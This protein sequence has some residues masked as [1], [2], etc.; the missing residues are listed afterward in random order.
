MTGILISTFAAI[1]ITAHLWHL[2]YLRLGRRRRVRRRLQCGRLT[3]ISIA[4]GMGMARTK[5]IIPGAPTCRA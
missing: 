2:P 1:L 3:R 5:S 4:G